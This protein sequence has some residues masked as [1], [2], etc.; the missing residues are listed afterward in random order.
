MNHVEISGVI[1]DIGEAG[2][3]VRFVIV[4]T[5][6]WRGP[7]GLI[8]SGTTRV[9]CRAWGHGMNR[10]LKYGQIGVEVVVTGRLVRLGSDLGVQVES[11]TFPGRDEG[12]VPSDG[13]ADGCAHDASNGP[14]VG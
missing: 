9:P 8:R 1:A 13:H 2:P 7:D 12:L 3:T 10:L 14:A 5:N 11:I 4:S 6:S